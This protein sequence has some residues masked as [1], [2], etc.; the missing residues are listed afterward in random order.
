MNRGLTH[1][2]FIPITHKSLPIERVYPCLSRYNPGAG[3]GVGQPAHTH[4][5]THADVYMQALGR[6]TLSKSQTD[7]ISHTLLDV[8]HASIQIL[9]LPIEQL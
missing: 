9:A 4:R 7:L 5:F 2:G 1:D 3:A 6:N 8:L